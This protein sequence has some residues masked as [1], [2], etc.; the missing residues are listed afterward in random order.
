MHGGEYRSRST[1]LHTRTHIPPDGGLSLADLRAQVRRLKD[2]KGF[3][4][5]L[6]QRLAYL[7]AEVGE[8]AA[9][10][11][12]LSR[13]GNRDVGRMDAAEREAV[14]EA[15]GMEIYDAVWNLLDLADMAGVDVEAAFRKKANLNEGR[16]W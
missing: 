7:T 5:T 1:G 9:E 2:A 13:D 11:L 12:K 10:V 4:I 16:E 14:V 3:D 15:L 8:I 6:D